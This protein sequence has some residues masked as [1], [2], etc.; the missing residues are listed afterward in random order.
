MID[1]TKLK[2]GDKVRV[3]MD[4]K[5]VYECA[6]IADLTKFLGQ[7]VTFKSVEWDKNINVEETSWVFHP[8]WLDPVDEPKR[9]EVVTETRE[10]IKEVVIRLPVNVAKYLASITGPDKWNECRDELKAALAAQEAKS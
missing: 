1:T 2:P 5:S 3:R 7:V 6:F 8:S 4:A 9:V 10:V